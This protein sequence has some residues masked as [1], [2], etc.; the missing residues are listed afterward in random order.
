MDRRDALWDPSAGVGRSSL[1]SSACATALNAVLGLRSLA[2]RRGACSAQNIIPRRAVS[3]F[4]MASGGQPE[5][6]E[7]LVLIPVPK[8]ASTSLRTVMVNQIAPDYLNQE[9]HRKGEIAELRACP[10]VQQQLNSATRFGSNAF[11]NRSAKTL[12]AAFA[13]EPM[14]RFFA[15]AHEFS[16]RCVFDLHRT[17]GIRRRRLKTPMQF[18]SVYETEVILVS[19][20]MINPIKSEHL[21]H[22]VWIPSRFYSRA[23][24]SND[25]TRAVVP[26]VRWDASAEGIQQ[27]F[28]VLLSVLTSAARLD[29]VHLTPQA[30]FV[31]QTLTPVDALLRL[32]RLDEDWS[33]FAHR[34]AGL[35]TNLSFPR[36]R[37]S[38]KRPVNVTFSPAMRRQFCSLHAADFACLGYV[39]PHWCRPS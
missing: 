32:E 26:S 6:W 34:R 18:G 11:T 10:R 20:R 21:G 17:S 9:Q 1:E 7:A 35:A 3:E 15:G 19:S 13:R 14:S 36:T 37:V 2:H 4:A 28:E 33:A 22:C 25:S 24:L 12:T 16:S 23:A 27:Y 5:A 29:D 38:G 39:P 31:R 8:A 30:L